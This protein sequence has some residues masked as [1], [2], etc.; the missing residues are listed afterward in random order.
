M[1][2]TLL[3]NGGMLLPEGKVDESEISPVYKG[4]QEECDCQNIWILEKK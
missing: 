2:T 3:E 4:E 1:K